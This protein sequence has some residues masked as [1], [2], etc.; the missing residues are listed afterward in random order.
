MAQRLRAFWAA[1]LASTKSLGNFASALDLYERCVV[2]LEKRQGPQDASLASALGNLAGL[3]A[4]FGQ[5]DEALAL[6]KRSLAIIERAY[7][8]QSRDFAVCLDDMA[9]VYGAARGLC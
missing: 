9:Q 3:K 2:I 5:Y 1:W 8:E 6:H 7:G 4:D